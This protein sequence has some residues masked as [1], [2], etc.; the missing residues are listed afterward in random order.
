MIFPLS[1]LVDY[2]EFDISPEELG[3]MLTMTGLELEA[4]EDKSKG[5]DSVVVT[6]ILEIS[7]HPN[8][9]RLS[10][11]VVTDGVEKYDVVCGANNM[12]VDDKVVLAKIG[13]KLP[14]TTKFPE[15]LKIKKSKIRGEVSEGM[16]CAEDELGLA[17]KSDGIMV[18]PEKTEIGQS[19]ADLLGYDNIIFEIGITPNRPDCLSLIGIAREVSAILGEDLKKPD[20]DIIENG[21]DISGLIQVEVLDNDACP[22]YSCRVIKDVKIGPSPSWLISRLEAS[23]I[24][25]INNVVDITNFVLLEQGQP[26]HAFD[27]NLLHDHKIVVRNAKNNE[28]I[29]TLDEV[30]RKLTKN[31][32]LICDGENPIALAGIMGGLNTE[33]NA[34]TTDILLESAYFDPIT[35]RKTSKRTGL[36]SESSYRFERGVDPNN[37]TNALNRAAELIRKIG[38]GRISKGIVDVYPNEIQSKEVKL[39]LKKVRNLLGISIDK[40]EINNLLKNLEFELLDSSDS[41]LLYKIPTFRVDIEREI[42]LIEEVARLFGYDNIVSVSPEVPM[43]ANRINVITIMEKRLRDVFV[44][45]GF[46]EAINYSFEDSELLEVFDSTTSI[47]LKNPLT[48]DFSNMRTSLLPGLVK[49]VRLNLSRQNQDLRLFES[50]KVFYPKSKGQLPNEVK[51]FAAVATGKREPEIWNENSIDFF[52]IKSVLER[53]FEVL[54]VDSKVKLEPLSGIDFLHP[55]NSSLIKIDKNVLGFI[56]ELHP[57]T[58]EKLEIDEKVYVLEIDLQLLS[59]TY[60]KSKKKFYPLPKYPSVK[61]DIAL[62]VDDKITAQEILLNMKEVNSSIIEDVWV[63]DVYKG[64]TLQEGK[65]S[66]AVS[67]ILR[68]KEKTLTDDDANQ[69]Q[70]KVLKKLEKTLGAELRSI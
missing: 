10:L 52:D 22:R 15:G 50:G 30:E 9:D 49:N 54:S 37:V 46:L 6:K 69:V 1:W 44:S 14:E 33:V 63:F 58:L 5:L 40:N 12:K 45:Y 25:S 38:G 60:T 36:R 43:V 20:I 29:T 26:L 13:T 28:T 4:L 62:V 24:R 11:C 8:A 3:E 57:D 47:G 56:G 2:V 51:K 23:G 39:S 41:E 7:Q 70:K 31:D 48:K 21:E 19:V 16:L 67:M 17:L 18:L 55:G 32:L 61:R 34:E 64:E 42:D 27:Y 65:K 59:K 68:D 53:S 66:V 35:I